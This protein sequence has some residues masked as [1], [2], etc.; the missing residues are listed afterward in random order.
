MQI[1]GFNFEKISA[2]KKNP[3][4]G[5]LEISSN[6]DIKKI[7]EEKID[8]IKDKSSIRLDFEFKV[9]YKPEAADIFFKGF[10][11]VLLEKDRAK[12]LLRSWKKKE[13]PEEIRIPLFNFI[14][15][16]SNLRALQLEEELNLPTHLPMPKLKSQ[17]N[18]QDYTG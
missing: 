7:T 15:T 12:N 16:K 3:P 6:I 8:M 1:I 4:K 18:K 2:E 14:L 10:V 13:M 11:V 17:Q 5:K 9:E